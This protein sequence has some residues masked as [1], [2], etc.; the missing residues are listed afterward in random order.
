MSKVSYD[1][2]RCKGCHF[3]VLAC[4]VGAVAATGETNAKGYQIVSFNQDTCKACGMCYRMCPD[5]AITIQ[6]RKGGN[7][8]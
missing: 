2:T 5:Y 3:C 1:Q 7:S 6:M 8:E 4:P